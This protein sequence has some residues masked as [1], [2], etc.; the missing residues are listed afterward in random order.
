[1]GPALVVFVPNGFWAECNSARHASAPA[2]KARRALID[3]A[4]QVTDEMLQP[5]LR[6]GFFS[7]VRRH[8]TGEICVTRE[9]CKNNLP[10]CLALKKVAFDVVCVSACVRGEMWMTRLPF[11]SVPFLSLSLSEQVIADELHVT[12]GREVGEPSSVFSRWDNGVSDSETRKNKLPFRL[13]FF[14]AAARAIGS[15]VG[16]R[17]DPMCTIDTA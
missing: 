14:R 8:V 12:R 1:M 5:L 10:F 6:R 17:F 15:S 2:L 11:R 9:R 16:E 3:Q 4:A 13:A 7:G